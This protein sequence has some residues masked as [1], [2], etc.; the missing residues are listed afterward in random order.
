MYVSLNFI[1]HTLYRFKWLLASQPVR[2]R[3]L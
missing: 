1:F 2:L 3:K